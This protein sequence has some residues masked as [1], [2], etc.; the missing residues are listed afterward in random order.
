MIMKNKS[1]LIAESSKGSGKALDLGKYDFV[2]TELDNLYH[3]HEYLLCAGNH[4]G[5]TEGW[6]SVCVID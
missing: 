1:V 3:M 4:S 2:T 5:L 6:I